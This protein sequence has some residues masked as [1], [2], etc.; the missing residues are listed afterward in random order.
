MK[1]SI[2]T[3]TRNDKDGLRQTVDSVKSQDYN[4]IEH[5]IVD[6]DS[7]DGT[8]EY[9]ADLAGVTYVS[10]PDDGRYD[11]MN[12]GV[13]LANG[14]VVWFMHSSDQ[15]ADDRTVSYVAQQIAQH[16]GPFRWGYGLSAIVKDGY[17]IG[18]GGQV[19]F[20]VSRFLLGGKI[21]PHQATVYSRPFFNDL[22]GY[23]T[24][25][26]LA[27]DQEFMVRCVSRSHPSVWPRV[28]CVFDGHGAGS[29]RGLHAHFQDMARA[30]QDNGIAVTVS[31]H[32]DTLFTLYLLALTKAARVM[33]R[34]MQGLKPRGYG[35]EL[36][37]V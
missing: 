27:A 36:A 21:I 25:F 16:S 6:A 5:I 34:L 2:I 3:I 8:K 35:Q 32:F 17:A 13:K 1:V 10:E 15:F 23:R 4:N 20:N 29:T 24:D 37:R 12:K 9:L 14:D 11:G 31:P 22:Q 18:V 26:G 30:R 19:P 7:T 28:L 33:R